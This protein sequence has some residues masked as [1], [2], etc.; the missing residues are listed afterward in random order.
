MGYCYMHINKLKTKNNIKNA[1][2]HNYREMHVSNAIPELKHANQELV[3]IPFKNGKQMDYV[4]LWNERLYSLPYYAKT[5][6]NKKPRSNNVLALEVFTSFT[7]EQGNSVDI[8]SWKAENLKWLRKTFN[9]APDKY[10][11][12]V[13]SVMY[14]GDEVGNVHC[15]A[16]IQP[17]DDKGHL[18]AFYYTGGTR[19][20]IPSYRAMQNSYAENMKQFGLK[21]GLEGS[22]ATHKDI[23]KFYSELNQAIAQVPLP[24]SNE[25]A[26]DYYERVQEGLETIAAA[27]LK[28]GLERERSTDEWITHKINDFKEQIQKER[29]K[30]QDDQEK[31]KAETVLMISD[32]ERKVIEMDKLLASKQKELDELNE[33]MIDV[34]DIIL[35][36]ENEYHKRSA[37]DV[38]NQFQ[39]GTKTYETLCKIDPE[40]M[41]VLSKEI[42]CHYLDQLLEQEQDR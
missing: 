28:K 1:Y 29:I 21:R 38:L 11:D 31:A 5:G 13:L 15:H 4:E 19:D 12:N 10:G 17:I 37:L 30:I 39:K 16:L 35:G 24:H 33:H 26:V 34:Q 14:H 36:Y 25:L 18:N 8:E 22:K 3:N 40:Y 7:R 42:E 32:A 6:Q 23:K 41:D 27:Y 2:Q 20:G 9:A